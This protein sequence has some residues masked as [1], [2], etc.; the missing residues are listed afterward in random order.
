MIG[1]YV[2]VRD[3]FRSLTA[4]GPNLF[5]VKTTFWLPIR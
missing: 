2:G 3:M 5:V 4:P 1:D